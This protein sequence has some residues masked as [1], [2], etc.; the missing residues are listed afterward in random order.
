MGKSKASPASSGTRTAAEA[1]AAADREALERANALKHQERID[2]ARDVAFPRKTSGAV[3]HSPNTQSTS[4]GQQTQAQ[5]HAQE[6]EDPQQ[7][8]VKSTDPRKGRAPGPPLT[9]AAG[10]E[11]I[12]PHPSGSGFTGDGRH[13]TSRGD[14][15]LW[16]E[17]QRLNHP[18]TSVIYE[19]AGRH[20]IDSL[21]LGAD[22]RRTRRKTK[23][24]SKSRDSSREPE[25]VREWQN[26]YNR[27]RR[28]YLDYIQKYK[29]QKC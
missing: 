1:K 21:S 9:T 20:T 28:H 27:H 18:A 15:Q 2:E 29:E 26:T 11:D 17:M 4:Q 7:S 8:P 5:I 25:A 3:G 24:K 6:E 19:D 13:V 23:S 10:H 16:D 12:L 22:Q 14:G